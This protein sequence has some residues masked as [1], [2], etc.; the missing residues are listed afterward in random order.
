[1]VHVGAWWRNDGGNCNCYIKIGLRGSNVVTMISKVNGTME[2]L[3]PRK[4]ETPEN[5][6]TKI[7]KNDYLTGPFTLP[8]FVEIG[9]RWSAPHIAEI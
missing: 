6:E 9:P 4:S 1:M 8:I 5:I 2:I 7:G 3:T